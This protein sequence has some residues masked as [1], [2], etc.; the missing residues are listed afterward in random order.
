MVHVH[1]RDAETF[2]D[3]ADTTAPAPVEP[4]DVVA[5]AEDVYTVEVVLVSTD[6]PVPV[7]A[8]RIKLTMAGR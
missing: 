1:L 5:T 3:I 7:L 6:G 8:R 2:D 4:G